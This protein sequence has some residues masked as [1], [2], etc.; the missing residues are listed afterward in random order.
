MPLNDVTIKN[1]K[2]QDKQYRLADGKGLCL[3]VKPT[4]GKYWHFR[5]R[6]GGKEKEIS[7]GVYP[8]V[9]SS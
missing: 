9:S 2:P 3:L 7:L 4:G 8:E 6:V 5:Y 1:S